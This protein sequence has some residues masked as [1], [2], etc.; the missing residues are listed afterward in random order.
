MGDKSTPTPWAVH[1]CEAGC[2]QIWSIPG[3]WCVA[4]CDTS[5]PEEGVT[6]PREVYEA[7]AALIVR[8]VNCH[9]ELVVT[10]KIARSAL[11]SAEGVPEERP[12]DEIE[13]YS[14]DPIAYASAI[15]HIRAVLAKVEASDA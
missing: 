10:L 14:L 11:D 2:G 7:N 4:F 5:S 12:A 1:G 9:E 13:Y 15:S 8:A 6:T 3:D